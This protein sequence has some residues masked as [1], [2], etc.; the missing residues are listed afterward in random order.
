MPSDLDQ[1]AV[2]A[3]EEAAGLPVSSLEQVR[4]W[5]SLV[6][7]EPGM[8]LAAHIAA[9]SFGLL[10][11]QRRQLEFAESIYAP[12]IVDKL[13]AFLRREG[14]KA[15]LFAEQHALMLERI[16]IESAKDEGAAPA[17]LQQLEAAAVLRALLGCTGVANVALDRMREENP[18]VEDFMAVFL[19]NGAYNSK[20][21]LMG[22]MARSV[23]LFGRLAQRPELL[24]T[25]DKV[26]PLDEWMDEDYGFSIE[27]QLAIGFVLGAITQGF[28][29]GQEAGEKPYVTPESVADVLDK[30]GLVDRREKF[31]DLV[32]GD[33]GRL[34]AEFADGGSGSEHVAWER[35]PLI[36]RPFL[37]LED[38]GMLLFSPRS[39][40]A[41]MGEGF[42]YRLLDAAQRRSAND[43][44]HKLSNQFTAYT[45]QLLEVYV[46]DLMRSAYPEA[47]NPLSGVRVYGEQPY[48]TGGQMRTSDVA[49]LIGGTDLVLI[50][51]SAARL[52]ADTLVSAS[53]ED[54]AKDVERMMLKKIR[55]LDKC[56]TGLRSNRRR[57]RARIPADNPEVD[58]NQ[59]TRIWPVLVTAGNITQN[60]ALWQHVATNSRGLLKQ[61]GVQPM[62]LLDIEDYEVLCYLVEKGYGLNDVLAAVTS[63]QF[64]HRELAVWLRDDPS[65]PKDIS[66]RPKRVVAIWE[67]AMD[68]ILSS[69]DFDKGSPD[70]TAPAAV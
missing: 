15:Q 47:E 67:E 13:K 16:L 50:E 53:T 51:V 34:Q 3:D 43:P 57:D 65:A 30:M 21:M 11:D 49:V 22:E 8:L 14:P 41:W 37:R 31:F 5:I 20:P 40:Q 70:P 10:G 48:G 52:R 6:P 64:L 18:T 58:M 28:A 12:P 29:P 61:A 33:R 9:K 27:E 23:E 63:P 19:Q 36:R 38:G 17:P 54:A 1:V 25:R 66:G 35:R 42:Y 62:K 60:N 55:Q 45:G 26:C 59:V 46:L 4:E 68:A 24:P 32:C 2:Y 44:K 7:F 39:I 56:V 69:I